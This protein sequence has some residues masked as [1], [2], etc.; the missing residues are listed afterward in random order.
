MTI[1]IDQKNLVSAGCEPK[2]VAK[3]HLSLDILIFGFQSNQKT[4]FV[5]IEAY[6]KNVRFLNII[7]N[8]RENLNNFPN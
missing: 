3:F 1:L 7:E 2:R 8:T 4:F 5:K 6:G